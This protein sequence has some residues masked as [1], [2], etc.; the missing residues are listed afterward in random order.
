MT[1]EVKALSWTGNGLATRRLEIGFRPRA[2]WANK[3]GAALAL[4]TEELPSGQIFSTSFLSDY[5]EEADDTGIILGSELNVFGEVYTG[6][7]LGGSDVYPFSYDGT[8][9]NR[10]IR[11]ARLS[12]IAALLLADS[13]PSPE[14]FV[15]QP[16]NSNFYETGA[17]VAGILEFLQ[18]GVPG[19]GEIATTD[20]S[21][22]G[23]RVHS[24]VNASG[25]TYYGLLIGSTPNS[26]IISYTGDDTDNRVIPS[27][28]Q[29]LFMLL[30]GAHDTGAALDQVTHGITR[31][32]GNDP[33]E[34]CQFASGTPVVD[35]IESFAPHSFTVS[36]GNP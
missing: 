2:L 13:F 21:L 23:I 3:P 18:I 35:R 12:P 9:V 31:M 14:W 33:G 22:A 27:V 11:V 6:T 19:T 16:Y 36:Q 4:W 32:A 10:N 20:I 1:L 7:A 17:D 5:V 30:Q 26:S 24:S 15:G 8:N 34:S 25:T 29:P 28:Y